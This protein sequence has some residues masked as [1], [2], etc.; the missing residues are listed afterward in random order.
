[1]RSITV[2]GILTLFFAVLM[3]L[4]GG[5]DVRP[6]NPESGFQTAIVALELSRTPTQVVSAI[7]NEAGSNLRLGLQRSTWLDFPFL[8]CY[9]TLCALILLYLYGRRVL[10]VGSLYIGVLL[11]V[12]MAAGDIFENVQLLR[13]LDLASREIEAFSLSSLIFWTHAKWL[14]LFTI[15]ALIGVGYARLGGRFHLFTGILYS[16]SAMMGFLG[17]LFSG[18]LVELAALLVGMGWLISTITARA[19]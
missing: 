3:S 11:A 10:R 9:S 16:S 2:T 19:R 12:I 1:M 17:L 18:P 6:V 15:S 14:S 8:L 4:A 7:G 13:L 5:S